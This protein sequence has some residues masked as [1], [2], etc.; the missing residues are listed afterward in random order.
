MKK[1]LKI[2]ALTIV[3][4]LAFASCSTVKK[5]PED[6][7]GKAHARFVGIWTLTGV[8]YEGTTPGTIQTIFDQ[9]APADFIGSTWNLTNS[10]EGIY[11][12]TNG[13]IQS[14][15]WSNN[16]T[17][18]A[19]FQFKKLYKGDSARKVQDGYV[20]T[21]SDISAANMTLKAPVTIGNDTVYVV[22]SFSKTQ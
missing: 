21:V 10:G 9:G 3:S 22:F 16:N 8:N 2:A 11:T 5:L 6:L 7:S 18:G 14:I 4:L 1:H 20:L 19:V 17:N 13:T 12:L 15:F